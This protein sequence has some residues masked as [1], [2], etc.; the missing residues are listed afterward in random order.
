MSGPA[1]APYSIPSCQ[2]ISKQYKIS[3]RE[4]CCLTTACPQ[5]GMPSRCN[6]A[7]GK[8]AKLTSSPRLRK[9]KTAKKLL[10][11]RIET[12]RLKMECVAV[13]SCARWD[14]CKHT[15]CVLV[16]SCPRLRALSC[17]LLS[18]CCFSL[19]ASHSSSIY[20]GRA[21]PRSSAFAVCPNLARI[22]CQGQAPRRQTPEHASP[23]SIPLAAFG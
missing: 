18:P 13:D 7:P 17:P 8:K 10:K 20:I 6:A 3:R 2:A 15:R 11:K 23:F 19:C 9:K 1:V 14:S 16:V 4:F 5:P 21:S 12:G 22:L